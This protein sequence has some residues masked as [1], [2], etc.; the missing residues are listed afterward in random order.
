M[1]FTKEEEFIETICKLDGASVRIR[2]PLPTVGSLGYSAKLN[3]ID[4]ER[5]GRLPYR[6]L[7][8]ESP[9]QLLIPATQMYCS[10]ECRNA[11]NNLRKKIPREFVSR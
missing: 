3:L 6:D 9:C 11:I 10:D 1:S 8:L 5:C 4:C 2:A 7:G